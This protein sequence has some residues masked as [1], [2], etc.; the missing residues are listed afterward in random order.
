MKRDLPGRLIVA[1]ALLWPLMPA[2]QHGARP[3]I[4]A[5]FL[6]NPDV[7]RWKNNLENEGREV[8]AKRNEILAAAG[9]KPGMAVA[10]VGAGTGL[11]TMMF[12]QAVKPGGRVYAVDISQ[13]FIEHIRQTAKAQGLDNVTGIVNDGTG[14]GLP[15]ASVDLV[16]ISDTYHHFEHPRETLASIRKALR[17]GGRMVV[18]DFEKIPGE[19]HKQRIDHVRADKDTA[20]KEIEAAGFRFLEEKKLMRENYFVV[21]QRP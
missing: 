3:D 13:A 6:V 5:P 18:I 2:A 16:F 8:Y 4:N 1:L 21:F 17:P 12:A 15:E 7:A 19:T 10:D 9:V 11:F 14:T 20:I